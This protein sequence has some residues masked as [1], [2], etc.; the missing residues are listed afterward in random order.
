[1]NLIIAMTTFGLA[2][3]NA[4]AHR[5]I[6]QGAV[7]VGGCIFPCNKRQ[8]PYK[9]TCDGWHKAT[10]PKE[11]VTSGKVIRVGPMGLYRFVTKMDRKQGIDT[12]KGICRIP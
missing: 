6:K 3:S 8:F 11:D 12:L 2:R 7:S 9:C 10:N 1:M 5:L 4:E